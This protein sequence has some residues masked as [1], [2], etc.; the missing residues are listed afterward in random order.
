MESLKE[1]LIWTFIAIILAAWLGCLVR[2]SCIG[3]KTVYD[4]TKGG[5]YEKVTGISNNGN[6]QK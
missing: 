4:L 5:H 2:L 1:K 6:R 3:I